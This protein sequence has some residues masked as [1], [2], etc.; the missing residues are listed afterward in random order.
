MYLDQHRKGVD[1]VGDQNLL[2]IRFQITVTTIW[3][4]TLLN[5]CL[6]SFFKKTNIFVLH[7]SEKQFLEHF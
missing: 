3:Q 5:V 1:D 2:H 6:D 7:D 4:E